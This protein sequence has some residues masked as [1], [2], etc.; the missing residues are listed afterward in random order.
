[1]IVCQKP[2]IWLAP[3]IFSFNFSNF[4]KCCDL[5]IL[6]SVTKNDETE[7]EII[8]KAQTSKSRLHKLKHIVQYLNLICTNIDEQKIQ[9]DPK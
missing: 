9:W 1:M 3:H 4:E 7:N 6:N 2:T 5:Y 8:R